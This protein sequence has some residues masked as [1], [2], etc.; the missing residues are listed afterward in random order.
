[1][2]SAAGDYF[3][4]AIRRQELRI[5]HS[6]QDLK[7]APAWQPGQENPPLSA[8]RAID[9]AA[10]Y[11]ATLLPNGKDWRLYQVTLKP[12][13]SYWYY[14]VEFLEPLPNGGGQTISSAG[15]HVVVLM[16]GAPVM[17]KVQ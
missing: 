3:P 13:E 7:Q 1:V 17:A 14:V 4:F 16:N 6:E 5:P 12:V 10:K 9:A 11:L 2:G 8:R 15:F